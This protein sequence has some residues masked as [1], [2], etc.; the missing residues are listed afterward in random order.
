[1]KLNTSTKLKNYPVLGFPRTEDADYDYDAANNDLTKD[2]DNTIVKGNEIEVMATPKFVSAPQSVMVNEGDTVRLPCIVDRLEGFV[3]LWKKGTDIITVASQII[4]K[5][6][7][8]DEEMNGN[9]LILGQTSPKDSGVH[10]VS[11]KCHN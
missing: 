4:D 3:M 1:M 11:I 2:D 7:R 5:R 8:L 9:H 10:L 6:V